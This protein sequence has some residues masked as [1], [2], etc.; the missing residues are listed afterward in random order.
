VTV[1]EKDYIL[2]TIEQLGALLAALRKRI[3]ATPGQDVSNEIDDLAARADIDLA[4]LRA[5]DGVTALLLLS[6]DDRPD[7]ERC[8]LAA[9]L[10]YTDALGAEAQG[11]K[12]AAIDGYRKALRLY[13]ALHRNPAAGLP[14][15]V[16]CIDEI[17]R[18][19]TRLRDGL[20]VT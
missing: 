10:L 9:E 8:W 18:R 11:R 17:T 20:E 6:V 16:S 7:P 15:A 3:L 5:V 14:E 4:L 2:R 12:D 19:I 13:L 1:S